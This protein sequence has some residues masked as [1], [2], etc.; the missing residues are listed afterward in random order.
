MRSAMLTSLFAHR[1]NFSMQMPP[2]CTPWHHRSA[3]NSPNS[4][5]IDCLIRTAAYKFH[6]FLKNPLHFVLKLAKMLYLC[7]VFRMGHDFLFALSPH[8][9]LPRKEINE[10]NL[11]IVGVAPIE[12]RLHHRL[13][14]V[15]ADL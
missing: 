6:V 2:L 1:S 15:V 4:S 9:L 8:E 11:T 5:E 3:Y 10:R 7:A 13:L 12:C 14:E